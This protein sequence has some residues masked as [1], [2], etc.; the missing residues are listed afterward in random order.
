MVD[1]SKKRQIEILLGVLGSGLIAGILIALTM[2]YY[3]NP[4]GSYVAK[5]VL[6]DPENAYS[7]RFVEPGPKGK[8]EGKYVFEGMYFNY[9]S[10]QTKQP[11]SIRVSKEQYSEFYHRI[12]YEKSIVDPSIELQSL[13]NHAHPAMLLLKV[14]SL[15]EDS[16]KGV[17]TIF[18]RVDFLDSGEYYR[19]QLRQ[20]APG[21]EWIY[22]RH[23]KIYQEALEIFTS[24]E[25]HD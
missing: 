5:N 15:G 2:L 6:L 1:S 18:S 12:A 16:S 3:Y 8:S 21:S 9:F 20:S 4:N 17:E 25:N 24:E 10:P 13:F 7:L 11:K 19:M 14:R 22:F 23:P